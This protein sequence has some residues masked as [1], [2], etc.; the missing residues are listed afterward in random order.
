MP[1]L[2]FQIE[3]LIIHHDRQEIR[4]QLVLVEIWQEMRLE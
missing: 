2:K 4:C 3:S 1:A